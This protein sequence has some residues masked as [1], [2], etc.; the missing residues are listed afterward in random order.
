M[1][2]VDYRVQV[3]RDT[4]TEQVVVTIPALGIGDYGRDPERALQRLHKMAAFHLESLA[5]E[6]KEPPGEPVEGEGLFV[7]VRAAAYAA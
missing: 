1:D 5:L 6:G 4:E 7:R 2:Y 3:E